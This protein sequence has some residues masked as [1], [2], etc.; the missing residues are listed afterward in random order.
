M[1]QFQEERLSV[2]AHSLNGMDNAIDDTIEYTR[3]VLRAE[4]PVGGTCR[5]DPFETISRERKI[6]GAPVLDNQYIHYRLA[7]LKTEVEM[8]RAAV[9]SATDAIDRY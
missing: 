1:L 5:M 9:Y 3:C 7:E 8:L 2:A 6:F 4:T